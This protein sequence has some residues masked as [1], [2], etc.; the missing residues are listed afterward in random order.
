MFVKSEQA[1]M[2]F[3]DL[4]SFAL[5][6]N[7]SRQRDLTIAQKDISSVG[8]PMKWPDATEKFKEASKVLS[9][10][11]SHHLLGCSEK[12]VGGTVE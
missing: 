10:L 8:S 2:E 11:Y 9:A 3:I 5:R 1:Y 4:M 12:V 6:K 7:V